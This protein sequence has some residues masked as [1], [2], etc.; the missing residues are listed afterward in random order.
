MRELRRAK[1]SPRVENGVLYWYAGDTFCLSLA[2]H[3]R[4]QDGLPV[5][6][7][8]GDS[9]ELEIRDIHRDPVTRFQ[10]PYEAISGGAVEVSIDAARSALFVPGHYM[11]DVTLTHGDRVTLAKNN[12]ITVEG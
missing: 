10:F 6:L 2:L 7:Q 3:L 4:D 11:Y 12:R 5:D 9:L 8:E 1:L